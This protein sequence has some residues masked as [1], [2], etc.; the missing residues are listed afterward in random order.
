MGWMVVAT[1]Y[2]IPEGEEYMET[3]IK[4]YTKTCIKLFHNSSPSP[5]SD[6]QTNNTNTNTNTLRTIQ[7]PII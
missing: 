3:F 1:P 6:R 5:R 4:I 7:Q 2:T